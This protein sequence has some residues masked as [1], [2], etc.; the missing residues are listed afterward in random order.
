MLERTEN[1]E[2]IN[3]I[4]REITM[5]LKNLFFCKLNSREKVKTRQNAENKQTFDL[6]E[7]IKIKIW[8]DF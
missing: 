6:T 5:C 4:F 1:L 3:G 8:S 7:K 2:I